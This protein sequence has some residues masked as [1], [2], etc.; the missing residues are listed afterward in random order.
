MGEGFP[1]GGVEE[2]NQGLKSRK[3][4]GAL[5]MPFLRVQACL[6]YF[7]GEKTTGFRNTDCT[8]LGTVR[9]PPAAFSLA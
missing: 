7:V 4:I 6:D 1:Y 2:R 5:P 8:P 9:E 3:G